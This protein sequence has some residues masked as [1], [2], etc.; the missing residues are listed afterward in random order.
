M[1]L[2]SSTVSFLLFAWLGSQAY[3]LSVA[4]TINESEVPFEASTEPRAQQF[5][6]GDMCRCETSSEDFYSQRRH[7]TEEEEIVNTE[8]FV[9]RSLQTLDP[10]TGLYIDDDGTF[11]LPKSDPKC[12]TSV[13]F[14][15]SSSTGT[16]YSSPQYHGS[17][18]VDGNRDL[19]NAA[20][21]ETMFVEQE[22]DDQKE[23]AGLEPE[24]DQHRHLQV[25]YHGTQGGKPQTSEVTIRGARPY[26]TH[27]YVARPDYGKGK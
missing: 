7:L 13:P 17:S 21:S 14:R 26:G 11:I 8:Q 23:A 16:T 9:V 15:T 4:T 22:E 20:D 27:A 19:M 10:E 1:K 12:A 18:G 3:S 25:I 2:Y 5:L 24:K 6:P